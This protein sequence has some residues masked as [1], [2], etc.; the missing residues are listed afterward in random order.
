[1]GG[2]AKTLAPGAIATT[3]QVGAMHLAAALS[4]L[5][6]GTC[7]RSELG[8]LLAV[9]GAPARRNALGLL[10]LMLLGAL[11][12]VIGVAAV[13]AFVAA[14]VEPERLASLPLLGSLAAP[15]A[16][17]DTGRLII[18]GGLALIV[19]FA[20][21][22]GFLI[23]NAYLQARY[24]TGLRVM[25]ARRL[26]GAYMAAPW[27]FHLGRN[28]AELLR[29]VDGEVT[30]LCNQVIATLLD[31]CTRLFILFAVLAF[32]FL[33]E[34]LITLGW[35]ALLGGSAILGVS[36]MSA[37]LRSSGL[38]EQAERKQLVQSLYQ[39]FGTF[40][41]ARVL[42]RQQFFEQRA[43]DSVARIAAINRYRQVI[44]KAIAPT[45]EFIAVTGLLVLAAILVLFGRSSDSI[46]VTISLFVV[47]LVRLR[48]VTTAAV[49]HITTLRFA[50][51][52]IHPIHADLARLED[53][54][55]IEHG[56]PGRVL[57]PDWD[58][59]ALRDV[60][61]QFPGAREPS[62]REVSL[63]IPR[64]AV[65]GLVGSTGA[66]KSTLT[67]LILGL[68]EPTQGA[69]LVGG[70]DIRSIGLPAWQR[71]I[72]YVPQAI[73]LLDDTIRRN[74]AVGIADDAIDEVALERCLHV[75]QLGVFI[76]RQ[77]K[78]LDTIV[79]EH[80]TRLSGG[81]RQR[82]GIARAL[83][84]N[85]A[86]LVLDEATSALDNTTER[87]IVQAI[88]ALRGQRT[89]IMIAHRLSSV[90]GCDRLYF[91]RDGRIEAEGDYD[92]LQENHHEFRQMASA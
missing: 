27:V 90:R 69:I 82:I 92:T 10:L 13:P 80:G 47:G 89:I 46:L 35:V 75:A 41:E 9:I 59:I 30:T 49:S 38:E 72:G 86:V 26:L 65:I 6:K 43:G 62:V 25:L 16:G 64:G 34:P 36:L 74:I 45:S 61:F 14:I 56:D 50:M 77:P 42:R 31:L 18:W 33:I 37:R 29:N 70:R 87:A 15:L 1:M 83:Y 40:K 19:I 60:S 48:E 85:P 32:L 51:V 84:H 88:D 4:A 57:P 17:Q 11:L 3:K 73:Y 53:G 12:E 2:C 52:S 78:G 76:R 24:V 44:G 68:L 81:E 91:L 79:G 71:S 66:G 67:D 20:L 5:A 54:I 21:K 7:M 8:K 23:V 63:T 22:N 28:T 55:A 58:E 39:A